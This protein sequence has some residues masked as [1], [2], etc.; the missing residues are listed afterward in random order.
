MI[1]SFLAMLS[2]DSA[3][4]EG[5]RSST[6]FSLGM[7]QDNIQSL[8]AYFG[9]KAENEALRLENTRLAY[10]NFRLQDA[11][12]ENI[13]LHKLLN[14]NFQPELNYIPAKII[15][16]SPQD[17]VTGFLLAANSREP[18][19][20]NSAVIIDK[21]LVGRIVKVSDK[22]A[23]CQN[24]FDPNSR[25]SVR[26][27]RNRELGFAV[28]D[29]GSGLLLDHIPNTVRVK[30]G[31]VL[32][33]SGMSQIF[34]ANIKVGSVIEAKKRDEQLFQLIRVKPAVNYSTLEEVFIVQIKKENGPK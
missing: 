2:S 17:F 11:F 18:I 34:P 19:T 28:W 32:F 24:L 13:R 1:F 4:V 16:F 10:E 23:I 22:F 27:Q 8:D 21:G 29:G 26:I 3:I 31:D 15:G 33:T 12:L 5:L 30:E 25:V 7:I 14:F 9:L 6:L 20:K